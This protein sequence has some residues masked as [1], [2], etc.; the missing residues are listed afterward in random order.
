M[1]SSRSVMRP[2]I[3]RLW[4]IVL[5][6]EDGLWLHHTLAR[7]EQLVPRERILVVVAQEHS[8]EVG[9]QLADW[10]TDNL[11]VQPFNGGTAP[12]VLLALAHLSSR[13]PFAT[14]A[15][16][17]ADLRIENDKR[18]MA[19]VRQ[20][21]TQTLRHPRRL[22]MLGRPPHPASNAGPESPARSVSDADG[23]GLTSPIY[24]AQAA[25]LWEMVRQTQPELYADFMHLRRVCDQPHAGE[26]TE[27]IY[28]FLPSQARLDFV[29]A[30][31]EPLPQ[32]L[33]VC[34]LPT[35]EQREFL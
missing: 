18:L 19:S 13:E 3:N 16:F 15:V 14:V 30:V 31:C 4:A 20:A 12:G 17:P 23:P 7:I 5:A 2:R 9:R 25:T 33:H 8:E 10:P 35:V 6:A 26:V 24:V 32:R 29:S 28:A 22:T 27:G 21:A 1:N 34:P 11:I